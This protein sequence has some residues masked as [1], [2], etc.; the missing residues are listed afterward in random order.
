ML[1]CSV[2]DF[3]YEL[4]VQIIDV[5]LVTRA[6][7]GGLIGIVELQVRVPMVTLGHVAHARYRHAQVLLEK[8]RGDNM[9]KISDDD[10]RQSVSKLQILGN[11]FKVSTVTTVV[12]SY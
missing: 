12:C 5:C 9:Q 7:N 4:G 10:I 6:R 1:L 3:Y 2:G 8:A 11:G